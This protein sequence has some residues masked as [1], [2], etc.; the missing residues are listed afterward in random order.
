MAWQPMAAAT[1]QEQA[2]QERGAELDMKRDRQPDRVNLGRTVSVVRFC[3][4]IVGRWHLGQQATNKQR[5]TD[6]CGQTAVI[7]RS[8][9]SPHGRGQKST[10]KQETGH[11]NDASGNAVIGHS[12]WLR[13]A[14]VSRQASGHQTSAEIQLIT[15]GGD[16]GQQLAIV[17]S[18]R[19]EIDPPA[20]G[21]LL[22][23]P[24]HGG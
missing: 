20:A 24:I 17:A 15:D 19:A 7:G 1:T 13:G 4:L 18:H 6:G 21:Q 22:P 23:Q 3:H 16:P 10:S 2:N 8:A 12:G 11:Q 14:A 5:S 9:L